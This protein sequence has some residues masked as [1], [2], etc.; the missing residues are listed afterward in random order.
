MFCVWNIIFHGEYEYNARTHN[1]RNER[2]GEEAVS[3]AQKK[4]QI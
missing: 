3:G 2:T 4:N 1:K